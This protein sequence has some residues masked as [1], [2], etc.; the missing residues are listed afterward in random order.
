MH[1]FKGKMDDVMVVSSSAVWRGAV[2]WQ[3]QRITHH[4]LLSTSAVENWVK[5]RTKTHKDLDNFLCHGKGGS[6]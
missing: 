5:W 2:I 6:G 3:G 1:H 4:F